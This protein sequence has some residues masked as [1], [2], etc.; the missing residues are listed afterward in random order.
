MITRTTIILAVL[1]LNTYAL[2]PKNTAVV[3]N[4]DD[5]AI[6]VA[7]L[8]AQAKTASKKDRKDIGAQITDNRKTK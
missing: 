4:Q 5:T 2:K 6:V 7:A 8:K 3:Y 1:A